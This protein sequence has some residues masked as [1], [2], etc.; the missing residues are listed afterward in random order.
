MSSKHNSQLLPPLSFTETAC[1][2]ADHVRPNKFFSLLINNDQVKLIIHTQVVW[3]TLW[4]V[5][6]CFRDRLIFLNNQNCLIHYLH[7]ITSSVKAVY[8]SGCTQINYLHIIGKFSV[9]F[10]NNFSS[11]FNCL[12]IRGEK[13]KVVIN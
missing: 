6:K 7:I 1:V 11:S 9:L 8:N 13:C 2:T 3:L 10:I 12:L 5:N 4:F